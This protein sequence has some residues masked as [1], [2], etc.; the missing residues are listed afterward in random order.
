MDT[1]F[2]DQHS[3]FKREE[4][5]R[6]YDTRYI[7][8]IQHLGLGTYRVIK[9]MESY[10]RDNKVKA[11]F[12]IWDDQWVNLLNKNQSLANKEANLNIAD[13]RTI[14]ARNIQKQI[15]NLLLD[16]ANNDTTI[17]W[18]TLKDNEKYSVENPKIHVN[19]ELKKVKIPPKPVLK[20]NSNEPNKLYYQPQLSIVDKM[21]KS[22]GQKKIDHAEEL[23]QTAI[24]IWKNEINETENYNKKIQEVYAIQLNDVEKQKESIRKKYE[25]LDKEWT[26]QAVDFYNMQDEQNIKIDKQKALYF[27]K[28]PEAVTEYNE[29]VLNESI[30][31]EC[32]P[33][34]FEIEYNSAN[35]ILIVEYTL[36]APEQFPTLTEVKYIAVKKELKETHLSE[37]QIAKLYDVAIYNITL[38]TLYALFKA[39]VAE[40]IEAIVFNGWVTAINKATGKKVN[41]C[42]VTIQA[43]KNEFLEIE[44]YNVDPKICFKNF[45]GISSSKLSGITAVQ[46]IAQLNKNDKRFVASQDVADQLNEGIN[47]AAMNWE[48]FEHLI[49]ELF[50]K[51]FCDNGGEVKVTQASRDGGVDAI[52]FDP[53]PIRGGKIVIQTK[54]YTNTVGVSAVRD[55]YGTVMNEGATKGIL[56][57]TADYGPDAYEF[58]KN[59]PLTLMNGANLLYLLEKHGH[60]AKID[61]AE[62]KRMQNG[63]I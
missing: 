38:K 29:L 54:R 40:A 41:N 31:P 30:Y 49:R 50:E 11:Q 36:P 22:L 25:T 20:E 14:E 62:A 23:Y 44:L 57:T 8:E 48:D 35:K 37:T 51:E 59:K 45:K 56:V 3:E 4:Y 39:D 17:D 9:D 12:K 34:G 1:N 5:T 19:E 63:Q 10:I 58:S 2:E 18:E 61:I 24:S 33:R 32:F 60:K 52:A 27:E 42:I 47:L 55:L 6:S 53:D 7:S 13:V 15:E 46:P 26:K 16:S 21:F 28:D 43:K